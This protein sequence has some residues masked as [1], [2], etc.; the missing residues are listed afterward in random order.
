MMP[1][2]LRSPIATR[3]ASPVSRQSGPVGTTSGSRPKQVQRVV[4]RCVGGVGDGN[5]PATAG[6]FA[7]DRQCRQVAD[8]AT[9]HEA[10]GGARRHARGAAQQI[11][12]LVLGGD[13]AGA[14]QPRLGRRSFACRHDRV[15]PHRRDRRRQRDEG[16]EPL[17]VEADV[18]RCDHVARTVATRRSSPRPASVI[19]PASAASSTALSPTTPTGE[20][21][22]RCLIHSTA[23]S[24]RSPTGLSLP[25]ST[26]AH[27]GVT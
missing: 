22:R 24:A 14:L 13:R 17:A 10:S 23:R 6:A 15:H 25:C 7:P 4:D 9:A 20:P 26:F 27:S 11:D 18:V 3:N 5:E 12:H 8:R 16:E 1:T 21:T 2:S 19:E